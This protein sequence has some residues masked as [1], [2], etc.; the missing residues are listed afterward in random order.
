[1]HIKQVVKTDEGEFT[2]EGD[3]SEVEHDFIVEAGINFLLQQG[4]LPFKMMKN[5]A[6]FVPPVEGQ[7]QQ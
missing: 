1:M 4:V 7:A 5:K 2:F 3:I 6:S